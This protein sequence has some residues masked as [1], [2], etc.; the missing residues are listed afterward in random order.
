MVE[1]TPLRP[2]RCSCGVFFVKRKNRTTGRWSPITLH[3]ADRGNVRI[4]PNGEWDVIKADEEY[5]GRR[6]LNHFVDCPDA[7]KFGAKKAGDPKYRDSDER[8][9]A[10]DLG[11]N[12]ERYRD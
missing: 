8:Q 6:Y 3:A 7:Q 2:T 12:P 5:T 11:S 10:F 4:Y 9:S 1:R